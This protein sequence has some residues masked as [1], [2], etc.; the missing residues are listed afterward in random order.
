[1]D[2]IIDFVTQNAILL[3]MPLI[4]IGIMI[5]VFRS[6]AKRPYPADACLPIFGDKKI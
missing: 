3:G 2:S 5:R 6:S 4:F 1:M